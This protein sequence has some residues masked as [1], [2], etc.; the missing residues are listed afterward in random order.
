MQQ[1]TNPPAAGSTSDNQEAGRSGIAAVR[2]AGYRP[3]APGEVPRRAQVGLQPLR[4]AQRVLTMRHL[5]R[6]S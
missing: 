4:L 6:C 2:E 3:L 5:V 1:R